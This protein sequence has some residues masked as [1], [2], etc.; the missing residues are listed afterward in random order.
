MTRPTEWRRVTLETEHL[1]VGLL[2]EKGSDIVELTDRR[3]GIDLMYRM[4]PLRENDGTL[5]TGAGSF[6][7]W[8]SGGWQELLPNGDIPCT[9]RG[10]VH[11]HAGE[12][13]RRAWECSFGERW[14]ELEVELDTLPLRVRKHIELHEQRPLVTITETLENRSANP[15][16]VVWGQHPAFGAPFLSPRCEVDIPPC[17]VEVVDLDTTSRLL[18]GPAYPWPTL[19][20]RDGRRIDVS[21][22][23]GPDEGTHEL[24]LLHHLSAGWFALR[25]PELELGLALRFD[26]AVF[27]WLWL[28]MAYGGGDEEPWKDLYAVALEPFAGTRSLADAAARG[29]AL[30]LNP[31]ER[32]SA[33]FEAST[34]TPNG[35]VQSVGPGGLVESEPAGME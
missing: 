22:I 2:P 28:W 7:D 25:N 26:H 20:T 5:H 27:R 4:R 35:F 6:P 24:C 33:T 13:W 8:Y 18:P 9:H 31:R 1:R 17:L 23:G 10:V 34:F 14:A 15:V 21:R 29:E 30:V 16:E 12:V 11:E 19:P 32:L 3:T